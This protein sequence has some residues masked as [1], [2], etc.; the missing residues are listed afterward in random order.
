MNELARQ[1]LVEI[2]AMEGMV[3][4]HSK[5]WNEAG[6]ASFVGVC[7]SAWCKEHNVDAVKMLQSISNTLEELIKEEK[8]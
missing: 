8:I 4:K 7:V 2:P 1:L 5:E 3:L 6:F